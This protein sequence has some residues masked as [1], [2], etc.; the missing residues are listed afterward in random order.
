MSLG[1]LFEGI[2]RISPQ[3]RVLLGLRLFSLRSASH[4]CVPPAAMASAALDPVRF[5]DP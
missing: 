4:W 3:R 5:F 2:L 1:E